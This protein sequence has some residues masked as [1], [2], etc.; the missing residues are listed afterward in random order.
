MARFTVVREPGKCVTPILVVKP[1]LM[2]H[3]ATEAQPIPKS[4]IQKTIEPV[5]LKARPPKAF[6]PIPPR[7]G[8]E[9]ENLISQKGASSPL[10]PKKGG[11][12]AP[13]RSNVT[14]S[15]KAKVNKHI[16]PHPAHRWLAVM[17]EGRRKEFDPNLDRGLRKH[18]DC[19]DGLRLAGFLQSKMVWP[20]TQ[21]K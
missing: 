8:I 12:L 2:T 20:G 19:N 11:I 3:P 10:A 18:L 15:H 16:P 21:R 17:E 13:P 9:L 4:P 7:P 14:T 5:Q 6:P 1:E